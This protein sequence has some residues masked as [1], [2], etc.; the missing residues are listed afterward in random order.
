MLLAFCSSLFFSSA[1]IY[2]TGNPTYLES[3]ED[4]KI[5]LALRINGSLERSKDVQ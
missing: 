1:Y 4:T 2:P 3:I 5:E